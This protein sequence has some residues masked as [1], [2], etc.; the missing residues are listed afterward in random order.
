MR[1][2]TCAILDSSTVCSSVNGND[3][4]THSSSGVMMGATFLGVQSESNPIG[5]AWRE[6]PM[7]TLQNPTDILARVHK[8]TICGTDLHILGGNVPHAKLGVG[9]GHEGI[10]DILEVGSEV[11]KFKVGDRVL[12]CC[13]TAC[14]KCKKCLKGWFG[15]CE[16]KE[17]SWSLGHTIDG[18][19]SEYV[20]VPH[21]DGSCHKLP[22]SCPRN[23]PAEDKYLMLADILPTSYEIG[24]LDGDMADGKTIAIVGVGPVGL[25]A[26]LCA[27]SLYKAAAVI[28]I[29]LNQGRL[30]FA[31]TCGATNTVCVPP[32]DDVA[33]TVRELILEIVGEEE[34]GVDV[35]VEAVGLPGGWQICEEIVKPGGNIAVLGVHGQKVTLHLER[36]WYRNFKMTAGMVHGF[37]I[38][39][40]MRKVEEGSLRADKLISHYGNLCQIE[41]AYSLFNSRMDG[42][43][44]M[45]LVNDGQLKRDEPLRRYEPMETVL[46]GKS[47]QTA[48]KDPTRC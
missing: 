2:A 41:E 14:G 31:K 4:I 21:A 25:A 40:L 10:V 16:D 3:S 17:G 6:R 8:T 29:D 38:A 28:A 26:L 36:M 23:S 22:E 15:N 46:S 48:G 35:V 5:Y 27:C 7:P 12:C 9:L 37:S 44:K 42:A 33:W 20:R 1:A 11:K 24:L 34:D 19:Q 30:D 47:T 43:L 18:F 32:G 39:E 45:L 13:V